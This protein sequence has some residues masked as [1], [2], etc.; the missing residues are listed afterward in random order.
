MG[1]FVCFLHF[2]T[3]SRRYCSHTVIMRCGDGGRS[4]IKNMVPRGVIGGG[5]KTRRQ[6]MW[7]WSCDKGLNQGNGWRHAPEK[8]C[9]EDSSVVSD[10]IWEVGKGSRR[11]L[12]SLTGKIVGPEAEIGRSERRSHLWEQEEFRL[13]HILV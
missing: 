4:K 8:Q 10:G 5:E 2:C 3:S 11:E 7:W 13:R 6:Q 1:F 12:V 9:K